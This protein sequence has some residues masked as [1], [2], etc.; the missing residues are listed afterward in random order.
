[1]A[2]AGCDRDLAGE[3]RGGGPLSVS[4]MTS[5]GVRESSAATPETP[6][7]SGQER[8]R[9]RVRV[10]WGFAA[11]LL[12][13]LGAL[14]HRLA[15]AVRGSSIDA[16][17]LEQPLPAP[18]QAA[19]AA[20]VGTLAEIPFSEGNSVEIIA[21]GDVYP[22]MLDDLASARASITFLI[23]FCDPGTL[24]ASFTEA[25]LAAARRGVHV[26]FLG[27]GYGCRKYVRALRPVL[28]RVGG[29][30]AEFRPIRWYSL[31]R[32]QHRN[33]ARSVVIDGRVAYT[34]GFGL[35]DRWIGSGELGVWRE[36]SVRFT[37]PAVAGIQ[38]AF[39]SSWAEATGDLVPDED[40]L[41]SGASEGSGPMEAGVL[42]SRPG[43]GTTTAQRFLALTIAGARESLYVTNAYFVPSAPLRLLL[44]E[45]ARRGVDVRILL[46]G[47]RTDHASTKWA[48]QMYFDE[49][50]EG[51][52]RIWEYQPSML[53]A[54]AL[55]ADGVWATVGSLNFDRRSLRLN[56]EWSLVVHD[57]GFG[58][59][60]DS[61]FLA[62]LEYARELTLD[63]HRTR[64]F[65]ERLRELVV[66]LV[67][68]LL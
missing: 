45:A 15:D 46:P 3:I 16:V 10:A 2:R 28:A 56:E 13:G 53:H 12:V 20:R 58:Q 42:A 21:D 67:A 24:S 18:G 40:L 35:A 43:L 51:G 9:R 33:H 8:A 31:H 60:M 26:R 23:Y 36:M 55:V 47:P 27:D 38:A 44:V 63:V 7:R 25:L 64:P 57:P 17:P 30:A 50:L 4:P 66:S 1:M 14:V 5:D 32:A 11:V 59:A 62:D 34:G 6:A 61:I 39:V 22:R 68:P 37:G 48:G 65:R 29:A 19:W 49:L 54:K 52:V 41:P